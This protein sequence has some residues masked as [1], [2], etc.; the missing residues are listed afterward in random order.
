MARPRKKQMELPSTA[1]LEYFFRVKK[2]GRLHP[3]D[4]WEAYQ[5]E[6]LIMQGDKVFRRWFYDKP[7]TKQ[8]VLAKMELMMNPDQMELP[9]D[10]A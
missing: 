1:P 3:A 2:I 7:D 4:Y 9:D 6:I 5:I 8:M 10:A